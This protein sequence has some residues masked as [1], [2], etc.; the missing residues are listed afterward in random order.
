MDA[1]LIRNTNRLGRQWSGL[2]ILRCSSSPCGLCKGKGLVQ[3][4]LRE[5]RF[6]HH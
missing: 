2:S 3:L 4:R 6:L 1:Y 5:S